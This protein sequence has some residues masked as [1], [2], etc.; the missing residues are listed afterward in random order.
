MALTITLSQLVEWVTYGPRRAMYGKTNLEGFAGDISEFEKSLRFDAESSFAA[1]DAFDTYAGTRTSDMSGFAKIKTPD[2]TSVTKKLAEGIKEKNPAAINTAAAIRTALKLAP[3]TI[4]IKNDF[5]QEVETINQYIKSPNTQ[6][7][8]ADLVSHLHEIKGQSAQAIRAQHKIEI[9]AIKT[10]F[11]NPEFTEQLAA[12]LGIEKENAEQIAQTER[13]MIRSLKTNH[14]E[15]L[16]AFSASLDKPIKEMHL[17][18]QKERDRVSYLANLYNNNKNMQEIISQTAEDLA[19]KDRAKVTLDPKNKTVIFQGLDVASLPMLQTITGRQ[20]THD[21]K[22]N[23]F[24]MQL[25]N[26]LLSSSYYRGSLNRMRG[27]MLSIAQAVKACGHEYIT[28]SVQHTDPEH[29][30]ELAL[31][32]F[33]AAREA[34]YDTSKITIEVNGK[35]TPV[36]E[37]GNSSKVQAAEVRAEQNKKIRDDSD[38]QHSNPA[39]QTQ[40][41]KALTIFRENAAAANA[42]AVVAP[43]AGAGQA[44]L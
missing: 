26:R 41:R 35:K 20:I 2:G 16:K 11:K 43:A 39:T 27:D 10:L 6:Y 15:Q 4:K 8:P 37:L 14:A 18:A 40:L 7:H 36:G 12:A 42:N 28:M 21:K 13:D 44:N 22:N 32:A 33:M 19:K 5:N 23:T 9:D 17:E 29:A 31:E 3:N 1:E 34:G 38:R 30:K 24:T 25:P